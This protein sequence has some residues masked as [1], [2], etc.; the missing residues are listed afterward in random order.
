LGIPH[1]Y[2][3]DFAIKYYIDRLKALKDRLHKLTGNEITEEKI[4]NAIKLYNRIREALRKISMLRRSNP[5]PISSFEF[6]K[7]NHI[8]F[9]ADPIFIANFFESIYKKLVVKQL[10]TEPITPRLLLIGPNISYGDNKILDLV[11][12]AGGHF[13]IEEICEG[14]RYYWHNINNCDNTFDSLAKG[15]LRDRVPCAFM[16]NSAQIRFDFVL[17]LIA[18]FNVSGVIWY[19]LLRC[20]TYDAESYFFAKRLEEQNIPM[21]IIESD[22]GSDLDSQTKLRVE[23]FVESLQGEWEIA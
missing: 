9:F 20:E 10:P 4:F 3:E 11:K 8:S 13:V 16:R 19:E 7:I 21:L 2:S 18:N 14:L 6:I 22:Y 17:E 12:D 1:Q 15:Y 23:A 5:S